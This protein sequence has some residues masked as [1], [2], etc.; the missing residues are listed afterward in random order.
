MEN[1]PGKNC[2][3]QFFFDLW[4]FQLVTQKFGLFSQKRPPKAEK[5]KTWALFPKKA[6]PPP[7]KA[8][9]QKFGLF[10]PQKSPQ[11]PKK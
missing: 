1:I 8:E 11:K 10:F 2:W 4:L 6:P 5:A 7:P 3:E 9:K